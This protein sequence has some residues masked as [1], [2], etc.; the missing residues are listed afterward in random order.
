MIINIIIKYINKQNDKNKL[1]LVI[2]FL[3]EKFYKKDIFFFRHNHNNVMI[4]IYILNNIKENN[5]SNQSEKIKL[6][7]NSLKSYVIEENTVFL[8]KKN[9]KFLLL[10]EMIEN[11]Y[12]LEKYKDET[13]KIIDNLINKCYYKYEIEN[14]KLFIL[15]DNYNKNNNYYTKI[16]KIINKNQFEILSKSY[17]EL[18]ETKKYVNKLDSF[19]NYLKIFFESKKKKIQDIENKIKEVNKGNLQTIYDIENKRFMSTLMLEYSNRSHDVRLLNSKYFKIIYNEKKRKITDKKKILDEEDE[20]KLLDETKNEFNRLRELFYEEEIE[21][22]INNNDNI[23]RFLE[24]IKQYNKLENEIKNLYE[25]FYEN[26]IMADNKFNKLIKE[27]KTFNSFYQ[28]KIVIT[29]LIKLMDF[30]KTN[31]KDIYVKIK[32]YFDNINNE[33]Y[34]TL[35]NIN[36][37]I[38]FLEDINII[39]NI[40]TIKIIESDY[41]IYFFELLYENQDAINWIIKKKED[42]FILLRNFIIDSDK[43]E[44]LTFEILKSQKIIKIFQVLYNKKEKEFIKKLLEI[45]KEEIKRKLIFN[46]LEN[47]KELERITKDIENKENTIEKNL[48]KFFENKI[49]IEY[50][51]EKEK[52]EI[53]NIMCNRNNKDNREIN[54]KD[55]EDLKER[56]F[57]ALSH[58]IDDNINNQNFNNITYKRWKTF[59]EINN[60][61]N[62]YINLL[63]NRRNIFQKEIELKIENG[64]LID[65]NNKKKTKDIIKEEKEEYEN[66]KIIL[67]KF[68]SEDNYIRF[69]Y[70]RQFYKLYELIKTQD[71][72]SIEKFISSIF[73]NENIEYSKLK[74]IN[75]NFE[76]DKFENK[77]KNISIYFSQIIKNETLQKI[78]KL[79]QIKK[80]DFYDCNNIYLRS[81][82]NDDFESDCIEIYWALTDNL[83]QYQNLLIYKEETVEEE[84][85]SFIYRFAKCKYKSL[86]TLIFKEKVINKHKNK[87]LFDNIK[88]YI[89]KK[90]NKSIL[91]IL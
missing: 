24:N 53:I 40:D 43:N 41:I 69:F 52:Y 59:I 39:I 38:S 22:K 56:S 67:S 8:N 44:H 32:K 33:N 75:F 48:D 42:D 77:L 50:N 29:G 6:F 28:I 88:K 91:L 76:N 62:T 9:N 54:I 10:E 66:E 71:D 19:L 45:L 84:I 4:P 23:K 17:E 15:Y 87:Y 31:K 20:K 18:V 74:N 60:D 11:D 65:Y 14:K 36:Q 80:Y 63:N 7:I 89:N 3:N 61:I 90:E 37:I 55:Y 30:F 47:Y 81:F 34:K 27:I 64:N 70:G 68:Y 86:F 72:K 85:L 58:S 83:P 78:L 21:I 49:F 2:D 25:I 82:Y 12:F 51:E 57:F 5:Q 79:N 1:N 35:D 73:N 16:I 13:N 46:Y 26:K